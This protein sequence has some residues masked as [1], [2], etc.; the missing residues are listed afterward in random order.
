[1][2]KSR[3]TLL[4]MGMAFSVALAVVVGQRLS[5]EAMAVVIGVMAGVVASIPTS[6]IVVW[7]ASR[8]RVL[9]M[10]M[11]IPTRPAPEPRIML[12]PAP[13]P[14]PTQTAHSA[15]VLT[16]LAAYGAQ[17][18]AGYAQNGPQ[19]GG[20]APEPVLVARHFTVIGGCEPL[21]E[22]EPADTGYAEEVVTWRR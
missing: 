15:Q 8:Q 2:L 4:V 17:S 7:F 22:I 20:Y 11:D 18:Y 1:M 12:M 19:P 6:L 13:Q 16:G 5:G 10:P 14:A 21:S 9:R 3:W